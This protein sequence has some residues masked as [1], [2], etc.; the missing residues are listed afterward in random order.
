MSTI[1]RED[2]DQDQKEWVS[3]LSLAGDLHHANSVW[4]TKTDTKE[5]CEAQYENARRDTQ[6]HRRFYTIEAGRREA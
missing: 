5:I 6:H 2:W 1:D 3:S 4:I